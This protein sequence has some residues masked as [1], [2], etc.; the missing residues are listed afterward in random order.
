M[1]EVDR[2]LW[3]KSYTGSELVFGLVCAVGTNLTKVIESLT[4]RL[5][6][7]GYDVEVIN[8]SSA[9]LDR[10]L[11]DS[12]NV[13]ELEKDKAKRLHVYMSLGNKLREKIH[14]A[15]LATCVANIIY[16]ERERQAEQE[17]DVQK[18]MLRK[19]YIIKSLKNV[20]EAEALRHIYSKG[21]YLVGVYEEREARKKYLTKEK[22]IKTSDAEILIQRDEGEKDDFGQHT[23]DTFQLSDFFVD[24]SDEKQVAVSIQRFLDIVFGYPYATP[25]F[26]EFAMYMAFSSS[27][28]SADL[29]RQT[30]AAICDNKNNILALGANDCP[31]A[32]GGLYWTEYN[33]RTK[34]Y[35]DASYGRDFKRNVDSNKNV[36]KSIISD[37]LKVMEVEETDENIEKLR[38]TS[39]GDL[40]EYGRVVHAEMDAI[41]ACARNHIATQDAEMYVTTFPCH[42][43]AKHII[44]AGIKK[45]V[46]I[47]PYPKSKTSDFY[48][49]STTSVDKEEDSRVLLVPFFGIG[50]RRFLDLFAMST[51][52]LPKKVRKNKAGVAKDWYDEQ[53]MP[54]EDANVRAQLIPF[55][56]L[57][58]EQEHAYSCRIININYKGSIFE[59]ELQYINEEVSN[60]EH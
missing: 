2:E 5:S 51:N 33:Y 28:R 21:F 1:I 29:S 19:A 9:I 45:V 54:P 52:Y 31:K 4:N 55:S 49:D 43:C 44:A 27:L 36:I 35:E 22:S 46:Y 20:A 17:N 23:R 42:N 56:Y 12:I 41:T 10:F 58:I 18:P 40:T 14:E 11:P 8:I 16:T 25:T 6:H 30:G 34:E 39:I 13:K 57:D 47:E 3:N 15:I 26:G 37:V 32:G 24:N 60:H 38:K 53:G 48:E 59:D 50:P 7:F